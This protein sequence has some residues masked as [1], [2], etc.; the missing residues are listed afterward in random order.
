MRGMAAAQV[1][2]LHYASGSVTKTW[3]TTAPTTGGFGQF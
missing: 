2:L 1:V 3:T